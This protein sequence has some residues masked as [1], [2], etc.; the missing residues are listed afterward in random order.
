M[1]G[2]KGDTAVCPTFKSIA[3][4]PKQRIPALPGWPHAT[5][6]SRHK[7]RLLRENFANNPGAHHCLPLF[8]Y[9]PFHM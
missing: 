2:Q 6:L 4:A 8:S 3:L 9:H 1:C 7:K 5:N